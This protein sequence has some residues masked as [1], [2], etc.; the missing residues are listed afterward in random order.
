MFLFVS[1]WVYGSSVDPDILVTAIATLV[2]ALGTVW[3]T[4]RHMGLEAHQTRVEARRDA[5]RRVISELIIAGRAKVDKYE[6][7]LPVLHKLDSKDLLELANSDTSADV[8][9][10]NNELNRALI[11]AGLLVGD[12]DLHRA[13]R[14]VRLLN[15]E[16]SD[17][18]LGPVYEKKKQQGIDGVLEGISYVYKLKH[19]IGD[20]EVEAIQRLRAPI[21]VPDPAW[22]RGWRLIRTKVW[23]RRP[24]AS[25]GTA[26]T[27]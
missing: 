15:M 11:Q 13:I 14:K 3:L 19:S 17:K 22:Q 23:W 1:R 2:G 16:F 24:D 8:G 7:L 6:F 5:Q 27:G 10:V 20:L 9:R 21:D 25:S 4:Q 26:G 18:A 12:S